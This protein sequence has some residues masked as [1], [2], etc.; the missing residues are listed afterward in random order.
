MIEILTMTTLLV[1][2]ECFENPYL[3][4]KFSMEESVTKA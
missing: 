2:Q 3:N 4:K 1:I